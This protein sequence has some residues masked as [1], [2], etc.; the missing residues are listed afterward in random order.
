MLLL[1]IVDPTYLPRLV[2]P[3]L[4][5]SIAIKIHGLYYPIIRAAEQFNQLIL[6][7]FRLWKSKD[8]KFANKLGTKGVKHPR[9]ICTKC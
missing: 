5:Y 1:G 3:T 6:I 8:I 7:S 4:G 9:T 2:N